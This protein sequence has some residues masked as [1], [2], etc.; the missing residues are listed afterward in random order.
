M[1]FVSRVDVLK[2]NCELINGKKTNM[3]TLSLEMDYSHENIGRLN[4]RIEAFI[5]RINKK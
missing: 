4:T 5:E 2:E 3:P 1:R